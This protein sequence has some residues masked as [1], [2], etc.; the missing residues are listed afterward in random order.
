M[1]YPAL[2]ILSILSFS[3]QA[4]IVLENNPPS[5]KWHQ[6]KTPHFRVLYS[7]G[8]EEQAQRVANNLEHIRL[9][10][11]QS[12]GSVPRRISVI[13]QNHSAVSNG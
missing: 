11:A 8:F 5:V 2:F 3:S 7:K 13:L 10:A 4:Q 1:R 6:V 12:L 9:T